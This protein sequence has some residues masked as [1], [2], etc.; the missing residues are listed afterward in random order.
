MID[1]TDKSYKPTVADLADKINNPLF[2]N[3]CDRMESKHRALVSIEYSGD[4]VLLGWNV[5]FRKG[6]KTLLRLYPKNGYFSVLVVVGRKERDKVEQAL[7][8]MSKAMQDIYNDTAEGMGQRWLLIDL[9]KADTLYEDVLRIV[10]IRRIS[11]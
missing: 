3:L 1:I 5:R 2:Q 10:D 7:S 11:A 4:N 8:S 9:H 6:G